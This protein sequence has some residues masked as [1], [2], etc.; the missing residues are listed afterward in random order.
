MDADGTYGLGGFSGTY[1]TIDSRFY[2]Q[3]MDQRTSATAKG[4]GQYAVVFT[5]NANYSGLTGKITTCPI[6]SLQLGTWIIKYA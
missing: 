3:K 5:T 6:S 2:G 4:P 1:C